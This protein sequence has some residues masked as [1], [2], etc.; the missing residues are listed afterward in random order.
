[1]AIALIVATVQLALVFIGQQGLESAAESS[2][3]MIQSGQAQ[4][5][6]WSAARFRGAACGTL[7][8]FLDCARLTVGVATVAGAAG[9]FGAPGLAPAAGSFDPGG[10][11]S[12]VVMRL[13]YLWPTATAPLGFDL[14]DQ[15]GGGRMLMASQLFRNEAYAAVGP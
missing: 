10:P 3:R 11:D 12:V 7:P 2:A 9:S 14:S 15:A 4:Q 6:G 13:S 5:A 1:M 8:P